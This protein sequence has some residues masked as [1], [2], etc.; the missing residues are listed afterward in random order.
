MPRDERVRAYRFFDE[1]RRDRPFLRDQIRQSQLTIEES[2]ELIRQM[3]EIIAK[4]ER[5]GRPPQLADAQKT[6]S[7]S[8]I[9]A[10]W[11]LS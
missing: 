8:F 3:D 6:Q 7:E 11:R 4:M 5:R 10:A 9:T 1:V 2:K